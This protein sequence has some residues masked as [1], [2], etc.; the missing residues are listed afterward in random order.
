MNWKEK[1]AS[2]E[3]H[4]PQ[5]R[6]DHIHADKHD[7]PCKDACQDALVLAKR[8]TGANADDTAGRAANDEEKCEFPIDMT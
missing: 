4:V 7:N 6:D 1:L 8:L 5:A 3:H 2:A